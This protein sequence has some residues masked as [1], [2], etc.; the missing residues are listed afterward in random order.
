MAYELRRPLLPFTQ[1]PLAERVQRALNKAKPSLSEAPA[2]EEA[3]ND[4]ESP[5]PEDTP[6]PD[7]Q[8]DSFGGH[9]QLIQRIQ[10]LRNVHPYRATGSLL[11]E[12]HR[13]KKLH[14]KL[15]TRLYKML[16]GLDAT[17]RLRLEPVRVVMAELIELTIRNPDA[18]AGYI[19][20][21]AHHSRIFNYSIRL[22]I[23]ALLFGRQLD[24]SRESLMDLGMAALLCK[25]GYLT[26]PTDLSSHLGTV[27]P[28]DREMMKV[29]LLKGVR[30]LQQQS[31]VRAMALQTIYCHLER[32]DGSGYPRGLTRDQ[33]PFLAQMLSV[34]DYYEEMTS[35]DFNSEPLAAS[36]A[37]RELYRQRGKMFDADVVAA[38]VQAIG[39]YP[40]G[41]L[42]RLNDSRQAIVVAQ[43]PDAANRPRVALQ[44]AKWVPLRRLAKLT[45]KNL[46]CP[47]SQL[48]VSA[49]LPPEIPAKP[50]NFI[51]L[52]GNLSDL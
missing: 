41:S 52:S 39:I 38:F 23:W 12:T 13:A 42:V 47:G 33:I 27:S 7:I 10:E 20:P 28:Q 6:A 4:P 18:L 14:R 31:N 44:H 24:L 3:S 32:Y 46:N 35:H 45:A 40:T 34:V 5:T 22:V 30:L 19:R 26:L 1:A 49:S 48:Y 2:A 9:D 16:I 37:V 36:D 21:Q 25:I 50:L 17:N 29:S 11:V 51:G 15:E 8:D 43:N